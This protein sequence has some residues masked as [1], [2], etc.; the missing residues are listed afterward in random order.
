MLM[1]L[2]LFVCLFVC[3]PY[4]QA[5]QPPTFYRCQSTVPS[6][7]KWKPKERTMES[8]RRRCLVYNAP[9]CTGD[10]RC[11]GRPR[12]TSAGGRADS[13]PTATRGSSVCGVYSWD[14]L[15]RTHSRS[16][17]I[18]R[19]ST[20]AAADRRRRGRERWREIDCM[21]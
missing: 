16:G 2:Y 13:L 1:F 10:D 5:G 14:S 19:P 6:R 8:H 11:I 3:L 12:E 20:A 21:M 18:V 4:K 15:A 17:S 7:P 9:I